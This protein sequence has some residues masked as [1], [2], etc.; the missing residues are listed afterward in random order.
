MR[1]CALIGLNTDNLI[2]RKGIHEILFK[3]SSNTF[4]LL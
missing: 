2:K 4:Q 3:R 1:E